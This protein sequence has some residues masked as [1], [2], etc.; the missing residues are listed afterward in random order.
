MRRSLERATEEELA[1]VPRVLLRPEEVAEAIIA[2]EK[3]AGRVLVYREGETPRL[4][5][6]S[7]P[8]TVTGD[9]AEDYSE[10]RTGGAS[11]GGRGLSQPAKIRCMPG[12]SRYTIVGTRTAVT[13]SV[14]RKSGHGVITGP[15]TTSV[16]VRAG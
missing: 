12:I 16:A 13:R 14:R 8:E 3:L 4:V 11:L 2:N 6:P 10:A 9:S 5:S 7:P 15:S 1:T